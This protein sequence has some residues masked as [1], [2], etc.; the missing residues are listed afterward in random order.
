MSALAQ[1]LH[2]D[3][4]AV[5]EGLEFPAAG[6]AYAEGDLVAVEVVC[7]AMTPGGCCD[8]EVAVT[9]LAA[10][11][12]VHPAVE[13]GARDA[14]EESLHDP[15]PGIRAAARSELDR[16]DGPRW[17]ARPLAEWVLLL[18]EKTG[19]GRLILL[20]ETSLRPRG[21]A[22]VPGVRADATV[23][24][25]LRP[26]SA[27][28]V[29]GA[30]DLFAAVRK[31]AVESLE[32]IARRRGL[33]LAAAEQ[34][35]ADASQGG[36]FRAV[37]YRLPDRRILAAVTELPGGAAALTIETA[38]AELAGSTVRFAVGAEQGEAR[39][40]ATGG[41][42]SATLPLDQPYAAVERLIPAFQLRLSACPGG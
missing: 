2:E 33:T 20:P 31:V 30:D 36:Q 5:L 6:G 38:A 8:L 24:L 9:P 17:G 3:L 15:H 11:G 12:N 42:W 1:N 39:L 13:A 22:V 19:S 29:L 32:R 4:R 27:R 7:R 37:E 18:H 35:P 21:R 40:S 28:S 34:S 41:V 25:E 16:L 14:F 10:P 26:A 23:G